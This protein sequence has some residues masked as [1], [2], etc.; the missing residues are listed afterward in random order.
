VSEASERYQNFHERREAQVKEP[1]GSLAL[2][3]TQWVDAP[4]E[5]WGVKGKWSPRP[6]G[7]PGLLLKAESGDGIEVDGAVVNGE[8]LLKGPGP[9]APKI[10]LSE[11][12][13]ATIVVEGEYSGLRVWDSKSEWVL[14]FGEIGAYEYDPDWVLTGKW[15]P[16]PAGTMLELDK[17][18]GSA[19][20]EVTPGEIE[21]EYQGQTY[22]FAT[23]GTGRAL[24]IVFAD[25]TNGNETYS[26]GRF[27]F[28]VPNPDGSVSLDFNYAVLPPCAFSYN[29]NCPIPPKQNRLPFAVTAG[30]KMVMGKTGEPL[31]A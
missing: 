13:N 29:F 20:A 30:E 23:I 19:K 27:L 17:K 26:V 16:A 10:R 18:Q 6:D 4:Q 15:K 25:E 14:G 28:V 2:V 3:L 5:I 31:H 22:S 21:F 1:F 8:V 9:D 24:Q 12:Q 7:K 11:N